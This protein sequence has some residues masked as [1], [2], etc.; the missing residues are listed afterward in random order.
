MILKKHSAEGKLVLAII[1]D[2][3]LGKKFE[4]ENKIL[5]FT[6]EFYNGEKTGEDEIKKIIHAAYLINAAGKKTIEFF[7]KLDLIDDNGVKSINKVPY[8]YIMMLSE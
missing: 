8:T 3:L 2:D 1:D 4:E 7:K 6:S 5:D